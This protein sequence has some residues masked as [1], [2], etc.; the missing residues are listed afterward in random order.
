[1]DGTAK[2][3][4]RARDLFEVDA[5][6]HAVRYGFETDHWSTLQSFMRLATGSYRRRKGD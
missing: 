4:T 2:I 1:M 3:G 6:L 5:W